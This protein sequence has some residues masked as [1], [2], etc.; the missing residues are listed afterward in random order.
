MVAVL[1]VPAITYYYD[2]NYLLSELQK[3]QT[4][5][6]QLQQ[7]QQQLQQTQQQLQQT[8]QQL[9]QTQQ[10]LQKTQQQLQQAKEENKTL[11]K[12]IEQLQ[13]PWENAS[14]YIFLPLPR[15]V[16]Q[17]G[18]LQHAENFSLAFNVNPSGIAY[19]TDE[20]GNNYTVIYWN[21]KQNSE[22]VASI[23][24]VISRKVNS[25]VLSNNFPYPISTDSLP[26][27]IKSCLKPTF[28]SPSGN[29]NIVTLAQELAKGLD[30]EAKI[31]A[32][33]VLWVN[34][35]IQWKCFREIYEEY[36]DT[37]VKKYGFF[38]WTAV[39]T[40]EYRVGV[41]AD[42]ADLAIALLRAQGIPARSVHGFV[43][44]PNSSITKES[45]AGHVW[46]QV[47]YPK[48]GWVNY[49]PTLEATIHLPNHIEYKVTT[50]ANE[51]GVANGNFTEHWYAVGL[52]NNTVKIRYTVIISP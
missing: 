7:A 24:A 33:T 50:V 49:D 26:N 43:A 42:F 40:L 48:V 12:E 13:K 19:V 38:T 30:D 11:R 29:P 47:W 8:Q 3:K 2:R 36:Y 15:E 27:D 25:N 34:Q 37:I 31:A 28:D 18:Y 16:N 10:Q 23:E 17:T 9:Q 46:I 41:C 22:I 6:Q 32:K 51:Y 1:I 52:G 14:L 5:E 45:D 39:E 4:L 20:N 21:E 44:D 35:N